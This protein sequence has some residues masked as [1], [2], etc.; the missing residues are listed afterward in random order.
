MVQV[1]FNAG[2]YIDELAKRMSKAGISQAALGREMGVSAT[3]VT[4]WFTENP[5]RRRQPSLGTI[6]RIETAMAKLEKQAK[7]KAGA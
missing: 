3:Q 4:R 5:E 1:T 2:K 7:R 6:E